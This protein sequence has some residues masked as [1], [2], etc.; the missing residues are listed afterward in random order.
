M[1]S[2]L[3]AAVLTAA[4]V[5]IG[6]GPAV[7]MDAVAAAAVAKVGQPAPAFQLVDTSGKT[8]SLAEFAGKTVVLEWN[9]PDCPFVK[10]HY[11]AG[12]MQKQQRA[13]TDT[14]VVWL[15]I[16]SSAPGKQGHMDAD[17]AEETRKEKQAAQTAYLLD[18]N[19][20]VGRAYGAMTTPHMYIVDPAGVLRYAGAIDSHQSADP[21][22]IAAATQYV[23]QALAE[24]KAGK[25]VS[26]SLTRP[27]GC[28]VKY[29]N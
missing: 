7:N 2:R 18:P 20:T 19:G 24:L 29:A 10:K 16:N 8:R 6:C 28:D 27:Y 5:I 11:G 26:V 21:D 12:N 3:L 25:P 14:G 9:N 4:V 1:K 23:P 17:E 22:D 15:T 13:A